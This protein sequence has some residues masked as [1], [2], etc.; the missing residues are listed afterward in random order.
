MAKCKFCSA[1]IPDDSTFC[2]FCGNKEPVEIIYEYEDAIAPP[3]PPEEPKKKSKAGLI[4]G[5][6]AGVVALVLIAGTVVFFVFKDDIMALFEKEDITENSDEDEEESEEA[7][8]TSKKTEEV[9]TVK[10]QQQEE[11]T[12]VQT[13]V[14]E[15]TVRAPSN[16]QS[17]GGASAISVDALESGEVEIDGI[18]YYLGSDIVYYFIYNG[19]WELSGESEYYTTI[20]GVDLY[21]QELIKDDKTLYV[22]FDN[23]NDVYV[24]DCVVYGFYCYYEDISVKVAGGITNNTVFNNLD[25]A[26]S[27]DSVETNDYGNGYEVDYIYSN[28]KLQFYVSCS[29]SDSKIIYIDYM[30]YP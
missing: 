27:W 28:D 6:I 22:Y 10:N 9:T 2:P 5:I 12:V 13:T 15:T 25:T 18:T 17:G 7:E 24:E 4:A 30:M 19:G 11:T 3:L 8:G 29:E 26:F 14:P 1:V 23:T 21:L 16:N 20:N